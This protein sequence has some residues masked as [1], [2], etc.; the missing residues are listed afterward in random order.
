MIKTLLT[1]HLVFWRIGFWFIVTL[2][3]FLTIIPT[4]PTP[5]ALPHIDKIYHF[6]AFTG[7]TFLMMTAYRK[8]ND[9]MVISA[10]TSLGITIEI[11]QYFVPNRGFSY[12]D[13]AADFIGVIVGFS[14]YKLL[15]K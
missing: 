13:M 5:I 9:F 8:L 3:L 14:L 11:V 4:P 2:L 10:A 15:T 7:T 12:E 6:L 1:S